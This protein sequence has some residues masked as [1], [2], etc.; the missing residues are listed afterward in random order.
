MVRLLVVVG[1]W[2]VFLPS[3]LQAERQITP[4]DVYAEVVRIEKEVELIKAQ[5]GIQEVRNTEP[6]SAN[7][8]PRH[9]WQKSYLI[10][11][12]INLF[13]QQLGLPKLAAPSLQPL[14]TLE[15]ILVYEQ[16][17]RLLTE[18]AL[19]KMHLGIEEL[20]PPQPV[21]AGRQPIDVFNKLHHVS[22][23]WDLLLHASV[24]STDI[25]AQ[26]RRIDADVDTLLDFLHIPDQAFPPA[27]QGLVSLEE[28]LASSF[29]LME[30]VQRLQQLSGLPR[31]DFEPFRYPKEVTS[32]DVL[33]LVSFVLAEL[34]PVKANLGL[35]H[36]LTPVAGYYGDKGAAVV[37]QLLGYVTNKLRLIRSM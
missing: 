21:I 33:N 23:Q 1:V 9:P 16:T 34:Q 18:I 12:K 28:L 19:L 31:V 20:V 11:R 6:V 22:V 17:Q 24:T 4:A 15:P 29:T 30:E 27:K 2:F 3:L 37:Q 26:L 13:R 14:V 36:E 25:Y 8:L 7:L 32:T 5:R 10:H 35:V